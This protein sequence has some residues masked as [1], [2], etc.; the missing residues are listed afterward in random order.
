[1]AS[2]AAEPEITAPDT[3]KACHNSKVPQSQK[4]PDKFE[5]TALRYASSMAKDDVPCS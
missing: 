2:K 5:K 3:R 4:Y 1:M